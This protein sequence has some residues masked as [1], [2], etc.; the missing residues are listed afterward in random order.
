[1]EIGKKV[2]EYRLRPDEEVDTSL[3][4]VQMGMDSLKA[5][6]LR[7]W[8]RQLFGLEVGVFEIMVARPLEQ[9]AKGTAERIRDV[10]KGGDGRR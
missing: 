8:W 10:L 3:S 7:R 6:E 5:V 1:M 9:L 2:M 4:L